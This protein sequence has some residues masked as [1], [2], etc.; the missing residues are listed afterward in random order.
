MKLIASRD[1]H[2]E[3]IKCDVVVVGLGAMGSAIIDHLAEQ[4][5]DVV[6]IDRY[7]PPHDHG[8]S[9]GETRITRQAVGEGADYVPF[10]LASHRRWK[11]LEAE[12]GESLLEACGVLVIADKSGE[13]SHHGKT[14]FFQDT[15]ATANQF[16]IEHQLLDH[17][18]V[19]KKFP[20]YAGMASHEQAYY[21]PQGGYLCPERCISVQLTRAESN[22]AKL[23]AGTT[24]QQI[25]RRQ[26]GVRVTTATA[27]LDAERVVISAGAW[28][29][30][31]LGPDFQK[32]LTIRRQTLHWFALE[33]EAIFPKRSPVSIWLYGAGDSDYFY[34]FPPL[35]GQ[36]SIK[37]ASEQYRTTTHPD[38]MERLVSLEESNAFYERHLRGRLKGV[39]SQVIDSAACLYTLTPDRKF[40]LDHHPNIPGAFIVSAC[41]GHGFKH[42]AGIGQAISETLING[43]SQ[44]NLSPFSL[45]RFR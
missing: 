14:D 12:S 9:H 15:I 33:P 21:E 23:L 17:S 31:L 13:N 24:V 35:P 8:S 41:S 25:E 30:E 26:G 40:I 7:T 36:R 27:L 22:G 43:Q 19:K 11:M 29:N 16:D 37:V 44:F 18:E 39:S 42:S 10:V 34:G 32:L 3:K 38:H 45:D 2:M 1:I 5:V 6:G 20:Q 4:N 28:A